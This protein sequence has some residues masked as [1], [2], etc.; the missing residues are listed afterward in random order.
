MKDNFI[1]KGALVNNYPSK[2]LFNKMSNNTIFDLV[3]S[4]NKYR[5]I[6][7]QH[8]FLLGAVTLNNQKHNYLA[9]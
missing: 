3:D 6:S 4:L 9:S 5:F 2:N 8:P 1:D 7:D